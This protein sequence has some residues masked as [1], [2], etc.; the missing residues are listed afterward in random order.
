MTWML[1][2][3]TL[4]VLCSAILSHLARFAGLETKEQASHSLTVPLH[5]WGV[6]LFFLMWSG[7]SFLTSS[8]RTY[9]LDELLRD[10]SC[11]LLFYWI[12]RH[13]GS[14]R[15]SSFTDGFLH[16]ITYAGAIAVMFG[17]AVYIFQPVNRFT[18][19][20]LD[21]RF[22]TDYWPNAWAQFVILAWPIVALLAMRVGTRL[23]RSLYTCIVGLLIGSLLLSYSRGALIA[24]AGQL[25]CLAVFVTYLLVR[26]VRVAERVRTQWKTLCWMVGGVTLVAVVLFYGANVLRSDRYDVQSVADKIAFRAAEGTSSINERSQFWHQALTLSLERPFVGFG[27]YSFRFAQP[28][29]MTDVYATSDHPHNVFLK[30]AAE[31]GWP[32]ALSF[33]LFLILVLA[34]AIRQLLAHRS[35]ERSIGIDAQTIAFL[36][37]ILGVV[38]HN[39]IDYNL[40]FVGIAVPFWIVLALLALQC[41]HARPV[42]RASYVHW[43]ISRSFLRIER[44]IIV[45]FLVVLVYEGSFLVSSSMGRRA[46][47]A[48][49]AQAAISWYQRSS[50][51][52]FSRDLLL[53][54]ATLL[55]QQGLLDAADTVLASSVKENSVDARVWRLRAELS[56]RRN[57]PAMALRY[58]RH[59]YELGRYTDLGMLRVLIDAG[60]ASGEKE[61]LKSRKLEFDGLFTAFGNAVSVNTHFIALGGT[62]EELQQIAKQ[63]GQLFPNDAERYIGIA[64]DALAHATLERASYAARPAGLLW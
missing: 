7:V 39:L 12:V 17:L 18:G 59:A 36:L 42:S 64:A 60:L 11:V 5:M 27:P 14:Y 19:T 50:P 32:A 61:E 44:T 55:E 20:F 28:H 62:P 40:Q 37:V 25:V 29:L 1:G 51:E 35:H 58:A 16:A 48:G 15:K 34:S 30:L 56:L 2:I 38:A 21:W 63:L 4:I 31:R 8:T 6:L 10:T 57:E 13:A 3:S 53:A 52:W 49:D 24:F 46:Q 23:Q 26:D 33:C 22:H 43:R 41:A 45:L 47:A 54:Y 9:G